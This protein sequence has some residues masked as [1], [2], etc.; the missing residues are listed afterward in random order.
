MLI[1]INAYTGHWPFKRLRGNTCRGVLDRMNEYGTDLSV[2]TN[3]Q[4]VFYKNTQSA[5]EELYDEIRS[6]RAFRDRFMP[7]AVINP[8]YAG[9]KD[10]FKTCTEKLGMKGIRVFPNY[11]DYTMTEPALIELVKMARDK[12][13]PVALTMR[14]VDE[15]QRSWMD[16]ATEWSLKDYLPL[17]QAVPDA[18]YML[19]NLSTGVV[20]TPEEEALVKKADVLFDTSGRHIGHMGNFIKRFGNDRFAFG[21]HFPVLDYY[22]GLLRIESMREGEGDREALRYKNAQRFLQL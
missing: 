6:Q 20:L 14:I 17:V 21:T 15:R 5:N 4:G 10:D 1:D 12:G 22:T 7:F 2:I 19:L 16:L 3:L 13:I 8:I 9:W 11:H 18:K